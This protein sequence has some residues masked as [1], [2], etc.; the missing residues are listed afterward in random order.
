MPKVCIDAGHGGEPG[1][2][3]GKRTEKEDNLRYA[4]ELEKQFIARGWNV[5]MTRTEDKDLKLDVRTSLANANKCDGE[6]KLC[7]FGEG[8]FPPF[9]LAGQQ[10]FVVTEI[11]VWCSSLDYSPQHSTSNASTGQAVLP[12]RG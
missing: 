10:R 4:Q 7:I 8:K 12:G 11:E 6:S 2:V 1:A 5:I 9:F 3:N